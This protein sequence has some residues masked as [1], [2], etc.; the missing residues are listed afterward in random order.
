MNTFRSRSIEAILRNLEAQIEGNPETIKQVARHFLRED[1]LA[2]LK[3]VSKSKRELIEKIIER[4]LKG[5]CAL[6]KSGSR[7]KLN[8]TFSLVLEILE[9][10]E[11]NSSQ[12]VLFPQLQ[13]RPE[14]VKQW[15]CLFNRIYKCEIEVNS[16]V[17][18]VRE[19]S[20]VETL[21]NPELTSPTLMKKAQAI[22]QYL[23]RHAKDISE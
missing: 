19:V 7:G 8:E 5:A 18:A 20:L 1:D 22:I 2:K 12:W 23:R 10:S 14:Q 11:I 15:K 3:L 6:L 13:Y 17:K 9:K 16:V 21:C 4:V